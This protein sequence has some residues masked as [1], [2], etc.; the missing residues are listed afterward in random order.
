MFLDP[1][2]L[3]ENIYTYAKYKFPGDTAKYTAWAESAI[4]MIEN[5]KADK[6]LELLPEGEKLPVGCVNLRHYISSNLDRITN[7]KF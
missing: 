1:Y 4:K 7:Q 2:H 3:R 5:E 6:L